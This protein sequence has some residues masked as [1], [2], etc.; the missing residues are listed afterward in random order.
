M[1]IGKLGDVLLLERL[2]SGGMADV[3]RGVRFGSNGFEKNVAIKRTRLDFAAPEVIRQMFNAEANLAAKFTHPNIAQVFSNGEQGDFVYIEMELVE[4]KSMRQIGHVLRKKKELLPIEIACYVLSEAAQGLDY[5]HNFSDEKLGG[6]LN[7]VHR[8]ISHQ[9]ILLSYDGSV[10][11]VD[12]GVAKVHIDGSLQT[13]AGVL[14]G[15]FAYMS[16][17]QVRGKSLDRRS[18]IFALGILLWEMLT[19]QNL[20]SSDTEVGI[21]E[22]I[23]QCNITRPS[24]LNPS[25]PFE[26]ERIALKCLQANREDRYSTAKEFYLEVQSF[27]QSRYPK[28]FTSDVSAFIRNLFVIQIQEEKALYELRINEARKFLLA[29]TQRGNKVAS[30]SQA[31]NSTL[32]TWPNSEDSLRTVVSMS[33]SG[34]TNITNTGM[35]RIESGIYKSVWLQK[36]ALIL[37]VGLPVVFIALGFLFSNSV[38]RNPSSVE[39][40]HPHVWPAQFKSDFIDQCTHGS[41]EKFSEDIQNF[42]TCLA[43]QVEKAKVLKVSFD[44]KVIS[45]EAFETQNRS[46]LREFMGS[47]DSKL[48]RRQCESLAPKGAKIKY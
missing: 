6:P 38:Q 23:R 37:K 27:M 15:K 4:G 40:V 42:C 9:N 12:F 24:E 28:F 19:G 48:V 21:L 30:T 44:P 39:G 41:P 14:K 1:S 22:K 35:T 25:V 29:D 8:D 16:P 46:L 31:S 32:V 5:I 11:L 2:A 47:S 45:R 34:P 43:D 26:L 7:I 33:E 36:K 17:E 18:D 3:Y 10:K 13:Q 20:F